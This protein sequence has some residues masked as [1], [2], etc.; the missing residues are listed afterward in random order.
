MRPGAPSER[1]DILGHTHRIAGRARY[2]YANRS[3]FAVGGD[4]GVY[5]SEQLLFGFGGHAL[6]ESEAAF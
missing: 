6:D 3:L 1:S 4:E 5:Q 2:R